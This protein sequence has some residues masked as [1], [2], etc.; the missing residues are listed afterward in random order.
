M[1]NNF[2]KEIFDNIYK[3]I[4]I[5][6][7]DKTEAEQR[8]ATDLITN[9]VMDLMIENGQRLREMI[10]KA[11]LDREKFVSQYQEHIDFLH[12]KIKVVIE[13]YK[14]HGVVTYEIDNV[15]RKSVMKGRSIVL[16]ETINFLNE[17]NDQVINYYQN[18]YNIT[19]DSQIEVN[20]QKNLF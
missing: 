3:N 2:K 18:V 15:K 5:I 1:Q 13:S 10:N 12:K 7:P 17:L 14:E 6:C 19:E 4:K 11:V 8:Q 20:I 9:T 16:N